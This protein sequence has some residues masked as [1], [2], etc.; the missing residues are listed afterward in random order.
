ME[1]PRARSGSG[2][3]GGEEEPTARVGASMHPPPP[4]PPRPQASLALLVQVDEP[5]GVEQGVVQVEHQDEPAA[6]Q[7]VTHSAVAGAGRL[8]RGQ[9]Q[10]VVDVSQRHAFLP[11]PL[12]PQ[13][14]AAN[15]QAGQVARV[16]RADGRGRRRCRVVE[17]EGPRRGA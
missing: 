16:G 1:V 13:L 10:A 5:G 15:A 3:R 7:H 4:P 9:L 2:K 6:G 17:G 11:V 8:P 12:G 14:A